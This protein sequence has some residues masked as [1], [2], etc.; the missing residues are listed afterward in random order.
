MES[1]IAVCSML[2]SW[3]VGVNMLK[4]VGWG[5]VG[6]FV[7]GYCFRFVRMVFWY[8]WRKYMAV[9][10]VRAISVV[11]MGRL[12]STAL[13]YPCWRMFEKARICRK[14]APPNQLYPK[15]WI[16]RLVRWLNWRLKPVF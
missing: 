6:E 9:K 16:I 11:R 3:A 7:G 4:R 13:K 2:D 10:M 14:M 5:Y 12:V 1:G 8:R 15:L